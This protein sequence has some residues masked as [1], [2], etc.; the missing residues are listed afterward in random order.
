MGGMA[1]SASPVVGDVSFL[2]AKLTFVKWAWSPTAG[3]FKGERD[4][5][6]YNLG[7]PQMPKQSYFSAHV[8]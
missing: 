4:R 6:A 8:L 2:L 3:Q 5:K 1:I 7:N